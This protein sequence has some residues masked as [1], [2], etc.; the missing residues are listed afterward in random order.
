MSTQ[1]HC[2][3]CDR[4][5]DL[6]PCPGIPPDPWLEAAKGMAQALIK[7]KQIINIGTL[8]QSGIVSVAFNADERASIIAALAAWEAANK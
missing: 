2:Q 4:H 1:I 5:P 3:N 8:R 7:T 6:D